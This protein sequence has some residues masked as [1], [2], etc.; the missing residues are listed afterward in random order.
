MA[1]VR[2]DSLLVERGLAQSRERVRDGWSLGAD[3]PAEQLV[4]QRE[5]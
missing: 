1:R 3:Q 2:L 5:A 4:G